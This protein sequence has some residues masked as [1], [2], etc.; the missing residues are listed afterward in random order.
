M[1][2]VLQ[3]Q[4]L[5]LTLMEEEISAAFISTA[6]GICPTTAMTGEDQT[7]EMQ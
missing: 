5:H 4:R 1:N 3:L 7:F 2:T 6:S